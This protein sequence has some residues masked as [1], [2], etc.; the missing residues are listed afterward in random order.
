MICS[1]GRNDDSTSSYTYQIVQYNERMEIIYAVC[2]HG[3]VIID[4][5][6]ETETDDNDMERLCD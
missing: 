3:Q 6:E 1:C 5:R 2:M 4:V